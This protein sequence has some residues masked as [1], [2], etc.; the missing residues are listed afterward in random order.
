MQGDPTEGALLTLG[1]GKL[2]LEVEQEGEQQPRSDFIPFESE[3][4]LMTT[5]H[6]DH[7]GNGLIYLKGLTPAICTRRCSAARGCSAAAMCWAPSG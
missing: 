6:H 4:R 7:E 5:L 2:G 3:H 1:G